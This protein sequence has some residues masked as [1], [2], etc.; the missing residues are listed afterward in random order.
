MRTGTALDA[1][2]AAFA[3]ELAGAHGVTAPPWTRAVLPLEE[4]WDAPGTPAMRARARANTPEAFRRRNVLLE[5]A[6]LLRDA[7]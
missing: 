3:E 2:L 7:A 4:L 6:A 5:R 1:I